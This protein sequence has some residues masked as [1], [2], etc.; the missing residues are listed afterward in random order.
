[1]VA[2]IDQ[3]FG[4]EEIDALTR[5]TVDF[6][7]ISDSLLVPFAARRL[8]AARVAWINVRWFVQRGIDVFD[9]GERRRVES[10]LLDEFGYAIIGDPA[11]WFGGAVKLFDADRYGSTEGTTPHG[12][13]GRSGIAGLFSAK[14]M[15]ATPLVGEG[16][17]SGH[18]HGCATLEEC[19][20]EATYAEVIDAEFPF[21]AVPIIAVLDTGVDFIDPDARDIRRSRVRRGLL[22]RPCVLRPAHAERAP[23]F[24]PLSTVNDAQVRYHQHEDVAR[25]KAVVRHWLGMGLSE[26][27]AVSPREL[28][29]RMVRQIAFGQVHRISSGGMF[30]S[31]VSMTGALLDFGNAHA[32]PDWSHAKVLDHVA[33]F[34]GEMTTLRLIVKSLAFYLAKYAPDGTRVDNEAELQDL[35]IA[36]HQSA[37]AKECLKL[38][39]FGAPLRNATPLVGF[40]RE[41]FKQQ[42]AR[43]VRYQYGWPVGSS[44]GVP[45]L[46]DTVLG[47]EANEMGDGQRE[48]FL[49]TGFHAALKSGFA[50][51]V[52]N[53]G[54]L[55]LAYITARRRFQRREAL[56]RGALIESL[57]KLVDR[58]SAVRG[59]IAAEVEHAMDTVIGEA[60]SQ[61]SD[62]PIHFVVLA[63]KAHGACCALLCIDSMRGDLIVWFQGI[64]HGERLRLFDRWLE[65]APHVLR[66]LHRRGGRWCAWTPANSRSTWLSPQSPLADAVALA[67][68]DTQWYEQEELS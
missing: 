38:F 23:L 21:G 14:G 50:D 5:G 42:Q 60:R 51:P 15:G 11:S 7:D 26:G 27:C 40:L 39:Q 32:L 30:S 16:A 61:W 48:A 1:M 20:R 57:T 56:A 4:A 17:P 29:E 65:A 13:S 63:K 6:R 64:Y 10:W 41:H 46:G 28:V 12:G 68:C 34:G 62:L 35:A 55:A 22:V 37:F 9:D 47:R 33:G 52:H 43:R 44:K 3:Y 25:T 59:V 53:D 36:A 66:D 2:V 24:R 54:Q 45:W 18:A 67:P 31:N 19:L 49:R 8:D 58:T